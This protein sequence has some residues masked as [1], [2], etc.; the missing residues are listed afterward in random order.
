MK[1]TK[2]FWDIWKITVISILTIF[3][4]FKLSS[5]M[6]HV[7]PQMDTNSRNIHECWA[8]GGT[9]SMDTRGNTDDFQDCRFEEA[10]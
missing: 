4:L 10:K 3:G 6:F 7:E 2:A 9:P 8:R 5:Y 1:N